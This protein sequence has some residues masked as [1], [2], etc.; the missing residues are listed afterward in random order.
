MIILNV[1]K[2]CAVFC[3]PGTFWLL[4][5]WVAFFRDSGWK[6]LEMQ[7]V[8]LTAV[9]DLYSLQAGILAKDST[10]NR[11]EVLCYNIKFLATGFYGILSQCLPS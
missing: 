1:Y 9:F 8:L 4:T 5:V 10:A 6:E 7:L 3:I 2:T 11:S